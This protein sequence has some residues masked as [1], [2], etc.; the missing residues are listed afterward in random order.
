MGRVP[1]DSSNASG[2]GEERAR[3][4]RVVE[5]RDA[6]R[7]FGCAW[8]GAVLRS[9]RD[10][11]IVGERPS[12]AALSGGERGAVCRTD[13]FRSHAARDEAG[14]RRA[15]AH[16]GCQGGARGLRRGAGDDPAAEGDISSVEC[17]ECVRGVMFGGRAGLRPLALVLGRGRPWSGCGWLRRAA[18]GARIP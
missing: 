14:R 1:G 16:E 2:R 3:W 17:L 10:C 12:A 7:R 15:A 18:T 9:L 5:L 4:M 8:A 6:F 13:E 11:W